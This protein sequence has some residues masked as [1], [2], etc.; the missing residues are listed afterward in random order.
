MNTYCL[1]VGLTF[2]W[3][4]EMD[5]AFLLKLNGQV[6]IIVKFWD[7]PLVLRIVKL[8]EIIGLCG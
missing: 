2:I 7:T 1:V 4:I 8:A 3:K 5:Q 6:L